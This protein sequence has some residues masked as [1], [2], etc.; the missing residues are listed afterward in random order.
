LDG[1]LAD[2]AAEDR[3]IIRDLKC[4]LQQEVQFLGQKDAD[5]QANEVSHFLLPHVRLDPEAV[6]PIAV[7]LLVK[8]RQVP[9]VRRF[10]PRCSVCKKILT[11]GENAEPV[12]VRSEILTL[13]CQNGHDSHFELKSFFLWHRQLPGGGHEY[14]AWK[15]RDGFISPDPEPYYPP[16]VEPDA[17]AC[18]AVFRWNPGEVEANL[19]R[20]L[21]LHMDG[22]LR[23]AEVRRDVFYGRLLHPGQTGGA[24]KGLPVRWDWRDAWEG[25]SQSSLANEAVHFTGS[26][27]RGLHF[28]F[29]VTYQINLV[30]EP[31]LGAGIYP[32]PLHSNWR[33]Y[34]LYLAGAAASRYKIQAGGRLLFG[35]AVEMEGWPD[36]V[37]IEAA[38][39]SA[40]VSYS[41][42]ANRPA[43]PEHPLGAVEIG[44]DFGT[45]NTVIYV[46]DSNEAGLSSERHGIRPCDLREEVYWLAQP[47][48]TTAEWWL[49]G[50][51]GAANGDPYLFPTAVWGSSNAVCLRWSQ[52]APPGAGAA[53]HGFK[54]DERLENLSPLRQKYLEEILYW[55]LPMGLRRL[56][57]AA[58]LVPIHLSIAYPL[59]FSYQQRARYTALLKDVIKSVQAWSGHDVNWFS[60]NESLAA[61]RA[62]GSVNADILVLVADMGGR[63]LDVALFEPQRAD[64]PHKIHQLGSLDLG[65]ELLLQRLAAGD[66]A[67]YWRYRGKIQDGRAAELGTNPAA[68]EA[69]R[70]LHYLALEF[71][72]TMMAAVRHERPELN[73]K[74]LR[75]LLI[76]NG[77]RLRDIEAG[78]ANP[79]KHLDE[80]ATRRLGEMGVVRGELWSGDLPDVYAAK[81]LV[82]V[83]ALKN[84]RDPQRNELADD[85]EGARSRLPSGRHVEFRGTGDVWDWWTMAGDGGR[86]FANEGAA[87]VGDV[88]FE[89]SSGPDC[90]NLWQQAIQDLVG[91]LPREDEMREWVRQGVDREHLWKGPLQLLI[92]NYW[93]KRI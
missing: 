32:K 62:L 60:V 36:W 90:P 24:F 41:L 92:E 31:L 6:E 19:D 5:C 27:I 61:V 76:G 16:D 38:N 12:Q 42:D 46:R 86:T 22:S 33:K 83:G 69:L 10:V 87:R 52:Q 93:G 79:K 54:W 58:A 88:H 64:Q 45:S 47:S 20:T 68:K 78:A 57:A 50:E 73:E 91:D 15:D 9:T 70:R 55:A 18:T 77:W 35:A 43:E 74:A 2:P 49:P 21:K 17:D 13:R 82:A 28:R 25:C 81:H 40:G 7:R 63:T 53:K 29:N 51:A 65:G 8:N 56:S 72:R 11:R 85:D 39:G 80:W 59:A 3:T 44:L 14:V 84:S 67:A 1:L 26:K 66:D 89:L 4:I 48:E 30:P 75:V 37:A 23:L 34:R 71:I